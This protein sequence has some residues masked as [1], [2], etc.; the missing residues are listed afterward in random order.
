MI[1][2]AEIEEAYH[3]GLEAVVALIEQLIERVESLEARQNKDSHNVTAQAALVLNAILVY[4]SSAFRLRRRLRT[5]I[6]FL[7]DR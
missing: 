7:E 2:R 6:G 3:A 5:L 1:T 4:T